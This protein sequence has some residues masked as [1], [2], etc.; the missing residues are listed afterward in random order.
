MK[1]ILLLI[2]LQLLSACINTDH[3]LLNKNLSDVEGITVVEKNNDT[4]IFF[5][6]ILFNF[7]SYELDDIGLKTC[8]KVGEVLRTKLRKRYLY[9]EGHTDNVGSD[10]VNVALSINRAN[11]IKNCIFKSG[12]DPDKIDIMGYGEVMPLCDNKTIKGRACNRR[13]EIVVVKY[14]RND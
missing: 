1:F 9:I 12:Y 4:V 6:S 11:A 14:K 7:G 10:E 13:V 5:N 2:L 8:L 3:H